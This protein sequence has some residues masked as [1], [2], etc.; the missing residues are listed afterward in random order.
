[1][2]RK[3]LAEADR[4]ASWPPALL[5]QAQ[6]G[7][8]RLRQ[9]Y[10]PQSLVQLLSWLSYARYLPSDPWMEDVCQQLLPA[11]YHGAG[12]AQAQTHSR[13]SADGVLGAA[14]GS[15]PSGAA[16]PCDLGLQELA[17]LGSSLCDMGYVPPPGWLRGALEAAGGVAC[18]ASASAVGGHSAAVGHVQLA[19]PASQEV[20]GSSSRSSGRVWAE[21]GGAALA[22]DGGAPATAAAVRPVP[23]A[24]A[25]LLWRWG[26]LVVRTATA[27][28]EGGVTGSGDNSSSSTNGGIHASDAL[29]GAA[30]RFA[31]TMARATC[32]HLGAMPALHLVRCTEGMEELKQ[33][34]LAAAARRRRQ[35]NAGLG[36]GVRAGEGVRKEGR[37]GAR[38]VGQAQQAGAAAV[39][40]QEVKEL[41]G[42]EV[43]MDE[44]RL[45]AEAG[46]VRSEAAEATAEGAAEAAEAVEVT[47]AAVELGQAAKA[48]ELTEGEGTGQ[49]TEAQSQGKTVDQ[50]A[51][52]S[53]GAAM[54][55]VG[56]IPSSSDG[57]HGATLNLLDMSW[58]WCEVEQASARSLL[59]H[60]PARDPEAQQQGSRRGSS[61]SN[62]GTGSGPSP[63]ALSRVLRCMAAC[64]HAPS[65]A[66]LQRYC[67]HT[68]PLLPTYKPLDTATTLWAFARLGLSLHAH[69]ARQ[70]YFSSPVATRQPG[71]HGT[72]AQAQAPLVWVQH[73]RAPPA[74]GPWLEAAVGV[75]G[76][77]VEQLSSADV[78]NVAWALGSMYY[79]PPA[80][81]LQ[82]LEDGTVGRLEQ[83][84]WPALLYV[85]WAYGKFG[86][87]PS[88]AYME[89][90]LE[91]GRG[92]R[93]GACWSCAARVPLSS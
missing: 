53:A 27:V 22:A 90:V 66:W 63:Y 10:G 40:G 7:L 20:T 71:M 25:L 84:Q 13:P 49:A 8:A 62:S 70:P 59:S 83:L 36:A 54:P 39:L 91:V 19:A 26:N 21:A 47:A 85:L 11:A 46:V 75:L 79:M 31:A 80:G 58:W 74:L 15:P 89:R 93:N 6:G 52:A 55:P 69:S 41:E 30:A 64:G 12:Q 82:R 3:G 2:P 61:N 23:E 37:G 42:A 88:G 78:Q 76:Q 33:V 43:E 48:A 92:M 44:E 60:S 29:A 56:S 38:D 18:A 50:V 67:Q 87:A 57:L 28:G 4:H 73:Q 14:Q 45:L 35:Q 65:T 32:P 5:P 16:P 24:L 34:V 1:M 86:H 51:S 17:S 72:H 81:W 77:Q 68:Q 9:S